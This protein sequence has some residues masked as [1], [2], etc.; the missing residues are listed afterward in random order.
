MAQEKDPRDQ[1]IDPE[2]RGKSLS[3]SSA[4]GLVLP[5][6]DIEP[7]QDA[8]MDRLIE[9]LSR[10]TQALTTDEY[11]DSIAKRQYAV[12]QHLLRGGVETLRRFFER[13][14]Q[15]EEKQPV[16]IDLSMLE[17]SGRLLSGLYLPGANLDKLIFTASDITG[18][19]LT[20]SDLTAAVAIKAIMRGVIATGSDWTDAVIRGADM[21]GGRFIGCTFINT[22][23]RNVVV[24]K[25]T[26][27]AGSLFIGTY[28]GGTN[29]SIANTTGAVLRGIRR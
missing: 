18:S 21:S 4:G 23:M 25:D 8:E 27:F 14:R 29:L 16:R 3:A 28:V 26:N 6:T 15:L 10:P 7:L 11:S 13:I 19:D 12:N 17:I 24:D 2:D 20:G 5:H 1:G 22:V 9:M